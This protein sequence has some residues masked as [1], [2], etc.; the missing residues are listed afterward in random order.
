MPTL[1]RRQSSASAGE[2]LLG[3]VTLTVE[4]HRESGPAAAGD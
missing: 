1:S 4:P 3:L 2:S